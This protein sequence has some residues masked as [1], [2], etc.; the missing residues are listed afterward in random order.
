[1]AASVA[2][3][4]GGGLSRDRS[5]SARIREL[6]APTAI[7][8]YGGTELTG[9][10]AGLLDALKI[11]RAIFVGHDWGGFVAWAMPLLYPER[12]AGVIGVAR[13]TWRF[14]RLQSC[15]RWSTARTIA[16]TSCGSE[17][18]RAESVMD[19]KARLIFDR[20][21]RAP[22]S[23]EESAKR[24][25]VSG[26]LD[27]NLFRCIEELKPETEPIV[28]REELDTYVTRTEERIPRRDQRVSQHR[29][30]LARAS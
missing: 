29:S 11:H 7:T 14:R 16:C 8:D 22:L 27:M 9:D 23:P 13:R 24:M 17:A 2:S 20:L 25:I 5:Q 30:Q 19:S 12:T 10:M 1:M 15:A 28:T 4:C 18:G 21:M 26:E 6:D 3:R